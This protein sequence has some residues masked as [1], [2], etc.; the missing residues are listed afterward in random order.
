MATWTRKPQER[1]GTYRFSGTMLV[2]NTVLAELSI[3]EITGIYLD[4]Q[5]LVR[6]T[7]GI[8]YLQV[9][10]NEVGDKLYFIDQ[11]DAEM[12]NDPSFKP[13]HNHCTL[14]FSHEY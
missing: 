7:G 2:T 8:D 14:L 4:I 1:E 13:E 11:C 3:G 5:E 12:M 6:A 9:Y 10:E